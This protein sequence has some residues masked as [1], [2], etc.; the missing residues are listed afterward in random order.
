M[1]EGWADEERKKDGQRAYGGMMDGQ[2]T[3]EGWKKDER[4]TKTGQGAAE[5]MKWIYTEQDT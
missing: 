4:R 1:E 5:S 3:D 2:R